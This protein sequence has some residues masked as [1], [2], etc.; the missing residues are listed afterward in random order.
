MNIKIHLKN[1]IKFFSVILFISLVGFNFP[2]EVIYSHS[3]ISSVPSNFCCLS[4]GVGGDLVGDFE[5]DRP[6]REHDGR[7]PEQRPGRTGGGSPG[8]VY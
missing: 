7:E 5:G 3:P 4:D 1:L 6:G 2:E 8:F